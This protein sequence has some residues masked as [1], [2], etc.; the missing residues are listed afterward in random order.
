[1]GR[2]NFRVDARYLTLEC[3]LN[4]IRGPNDKP[5]L[6][7]LRPLFLLVIDI[8]LPE[9]LALCRIY[10]V[11]NSQPTQALNVVVKPFILGAVYRNEVSVEFFNRGR[12]HESSRAAERQNIHQLGQFNRI[13]FHDCLE[14]H[15]WHDLALKETSSNL[16]V[17]RHTVSVSSNS[18]KIRILLF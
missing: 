14:V 10:F 6:A 17:H 3:P 13:F 1:M 15:F 2:F 11:F 8:N 12:V 16:E 7:N 18:K 9:M 4:C 5:S